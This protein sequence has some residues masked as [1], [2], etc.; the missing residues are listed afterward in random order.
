[1]RSLAF[2]FLLCGCATV[3]TGTSQQIRVATEPPGAACTATRNGEVVATLA[4]TPGAFEVGKGV[5]HV[6]I[7]CRKPGYLEAVATAASHLNTSTL[8]NHA[9]P[10]IIGLGVD[11]ASGAMYRYAG[12]V[13]LR[14]VS[15]EFESEAERDATFYGLARIAE[16]EAK[17]ERDAVWRAC[18]AD[19]DAA[20]RDFDAAL[21]AKLARLEQQR[22]SA[23]VK[24]A[25]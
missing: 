14:M 11:S 1:M 12:V 18:R 4:A 9:G 23:K 25:S 2:S 20:L 24:R 16:V 19:C 15:E 10:G 17:G 22:L 21:A 13:E 5:G 3:L 8:W 6:K 7:A